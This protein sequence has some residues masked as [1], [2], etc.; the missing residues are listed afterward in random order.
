MVERLRNPGR[1]RRWLLSR[2]IPDPAPACS[3]RASLSNPGR[4]RAW[5]NH[6]T[7]RSARWNSGRG[8]TGDW[9]KAQPIAPVPSATAITALRSLTM[10]EILSVPVPTQPAMAVDRPATHH[11]CTAGPIARPDRSSR[12]V[13][14]AQSQRQ[15]CAN[16]YIHRPGRPQ[17]MSRIRRTGI[18]ANAWVIIPARICQ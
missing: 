3:F 16:R 10:T 8:V 5:G 4:T 9:E 12:P 13:A 7:H 6:R 17:T 15:R 2:A 1:V 14:T 11:P 18:G